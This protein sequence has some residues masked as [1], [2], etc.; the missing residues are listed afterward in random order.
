MTEAKDE[1]VVEDPP[2]PPCLGELV[3]KLLDS[4]RS[5]YVN[6]RRFPFDFHQNLSG[7]Y[8][9]FL[10]GEPL[11]SSNGQDKGKDEAS[12]VELVDGKLQRPPG[13]PHV[14]NLPAPG[15]KWFSDVQE[16]KK[17]PL[18]RVMDHK[19]VQ[20]DLNHKFPRVKS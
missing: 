17:L 18:F 6:R 11:D 2:P 12:D 13:A 8:K 15:K 5:H 16:V 19:L 20:R 9:P 1:T 14:S 7:A 10:R 3:E 4:E